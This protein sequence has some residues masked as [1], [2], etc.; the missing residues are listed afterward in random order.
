MN[1]GGIPS[2][3][4]RGIRKVFFEAYAL[5]DRQY[6]AIYNV[7]GS[8]KRQET[9]VITASLGLYRKK[10]EGNSPDFD[11]AQEVWKKV[12]T[13]STW[14]LGLEITQEGISSFGPALA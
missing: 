7:V 3:L 5:M 14:A 2:L 1:R 4:E 11:V 8:Q 13:H 6:E 9:D 10:T 12:Y